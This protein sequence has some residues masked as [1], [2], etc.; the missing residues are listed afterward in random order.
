MLDERKEIPC[1]LPNFS[2]KKKKKKK[3]ALVNF[4]FFQ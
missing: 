1:L 3:K 2:K 4:D